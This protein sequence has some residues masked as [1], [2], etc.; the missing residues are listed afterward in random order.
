MSTT[1]KLGGFDELR[2]QLQELTPHL[3]EEAGQIVTSHAEQAATT[4]RVAYHEHRK[5]GN[6]ERG[7]KV[8]Q[9]HHSGA[10]AV[11]RVRSTARHASI[12]E[13]GTQAR[14]T[15]IGANRGAMPPAHVFVPAVVK[16]RRAMV[17]D[18]IHLVES[19]GLTVK[20]TS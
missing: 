15:D 2:R 8:D 14:H 9:A 4:I 19:Q 5:T 1:L 18:L 13:Y 7:V 11:A 20:G 17:T 6:L 12:F 3:A 10:G 16:E